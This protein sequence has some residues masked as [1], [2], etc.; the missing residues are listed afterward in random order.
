MKRAMLLVTL[1][2]V[3]LSSAQQKPQQAAQ[4][5]P[6]FS[7]LALKA[8][9]AS[10]NGAPRQVV[11]SALTDAET[12]A[13]TPAEQSVIEKL[14]G[15]DSNY[16]SEMEVGFGWEQS[17]ENEYKTVTEI[18]ECKTPFHERTQRWAVLTALCVE[19]WK[20]ALKARRA[21]QAACIFHR[22]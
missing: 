19:K 1:A 5:R 4:L 10:S 13:N 15:F 17:C 16:Q 7:K 8:L 18:I 9:I 20:A 12:E 22:Q 6:A 14:R 3:T 21:D 2:L 11:E